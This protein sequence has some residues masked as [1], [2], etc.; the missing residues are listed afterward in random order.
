MTSN[1]D[2]KLT[3]NGI[4]FHLDVE[5]WNSVE[6]VRRD[7]SWSYTSSVISSEMP[8]QNMKLL[9]ISFWVGTCTEIDCWNTGEI[10]S[11]GLGRGCP[12]TVPPYTFTLY[13]FPSSLKTSQDIF[14]VLLP[15]FGSMT[16]MKFT[17]SVASSANERLST[18]FSH[19][20]NSLA[21]W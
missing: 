20:R 17:A 7:H 18:F 6:R 10:V 13:Y 8:Q 3:E 12:S 5:I 16:A 4:F 15:T 1:T 19:L 11:S 14:Y 21:W 2:G 9:L